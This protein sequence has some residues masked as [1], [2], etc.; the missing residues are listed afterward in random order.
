MKMWAEQEEAEAFSKPGVKLV[1][2]QSSGKLK[3]AKVHN[4]PMSAKVLLQKFSSND[5]G[6]KVPHHKKKKKNDN[7]NSKLS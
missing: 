3:T 1:N 7:N 4:F 6:A 5:Q 2:I